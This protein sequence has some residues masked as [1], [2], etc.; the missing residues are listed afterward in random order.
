[1]L[2]KVFQYFSNTYGSHEVLNINPNIFTR[3][4]DEKVAEK[5]LTSLQHSLAVGE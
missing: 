1:M 5:V 3:R 4:I 2:L